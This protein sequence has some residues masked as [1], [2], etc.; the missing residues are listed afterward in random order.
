MKRKFLFL[1]FCAVAICSP[2][3][4]FKKNPETSLKKQTARA[5]S[6]EIPPGFTLDLSR[7]DQ[8][9]RKEYFKN[10]SIER[11][12]IPAYFNLG[13]NVNRNI[14][15]EIK[16]IRVSDGM[17]PNS[18]V[19]NTLT[20]KGLS[21]TGIGG[22]MEF[23]VNEITYLQLGYN[24]TSLQYQIDSLGTSLGTVTSTLND[25]FFS[26]AVYAGPV[27]INIGDV[28]SASRNGFNLNMY[29]GLGIQLYQGLSVSANYQVFGIGVL[30]LKTETGYMK[31]LKETDRYLYSSTATGVDLSYQHL[32]TF[33]LTLSVD[34]FFFAKEKNRYRE[35]LASYRAWKSVANSVQETDDVPLP[36]PVPPPV[37][38]SG[39][40]KYSDQELQRM[41]D[42]AVQK[43][44]Y[45]VAEQIQNE[46]NRRATAVPAGDLTTM[47]DTQL[48]SALK[49]A[50]QKEDY[51]TA[52][53]IQK[54]LKRRET[55]KKEQP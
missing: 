17:L 54:E 22:Q 30:P 2:Q 12:K 34:L 15:R 41:L 8:Y 32:S 31:D 38:T 45:D 36:A 35:E 44:Q 55:Q 43:E 19:M 47:S 49:A 52:G 28:F 33:Q 53:K 10:L 23:A 51:D 48:Q 21:S 4:A 25:I 16:L 39:Y 37:K 24:H 6:S 18:V 3:K 40:T 9:Q 29:G 20:G 13:V 46:I 14:P 1:L 42:A 27:R 5:D 11:D 7:F 50:I 26:F